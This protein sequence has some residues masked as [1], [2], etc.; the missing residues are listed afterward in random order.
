MANE[1][2][3][4]ANGS[5]AANELANAEA[6]LNGG[7]KDGEQAG[8]KDGD[9][10]AD[11]G[12]G[13]GDPNAQAGGDADGDGEGEDTHGADD[14]GEKSRLGRKVARLETLVGNSLAQ[15]ARSIETLATIGQ[16]AAAKNEPEEDPEPVL[17]EYP[18]KQEIQ[19]HGA[20]VRRQAVQEVKKISENSANADKEYADTYLKL[21]AQLVD[22][23][24]EPEIFAKL[25][26][27]KD[28][29]CNKKHTGDPRTDLMLNFKNATLAVMSGLRKPKPKVQGKDGKGVDLGNGNETHEKPFNRAEALADMSSL[30][31][32]A[33]ENLSDAALKQV[34][35]IK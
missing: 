4:A 2:N 8:K 23:E 19:D 34:L 21:L 12:S 31:R 6:L 27:E 24:K 5:D 26:D 15:M 7:K 35:K 17:S 18:T 32:A 28:T 25:V 10:G 29:S 1:D 3:P 30:E 14:H 13:E 16:K 11:S 9:P 22:P 20:W 33:A